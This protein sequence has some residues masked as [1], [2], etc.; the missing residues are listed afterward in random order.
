[1]YNIIAKFTLNIDHV[2]SYC[3]C[4]ATSYYTIHTPKLWD[5]LIHAL[6][7]VIYAC[8]SNNNIIILL[9][10]VLNITGINSIQ[11]IILNL[12]ESDVAS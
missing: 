10:I 7:F 2:N 3:T 1:M 9:N 4:H 12:C 6:N 8:S 5:T 11:L